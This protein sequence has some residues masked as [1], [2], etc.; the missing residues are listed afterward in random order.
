MQYLSKFSL[1]IFVLAATIF[2]GCKKSPVDPEVVAKPYIPPVASGPRII[3]VSGDSGSDASL[4][5]FNVATPY[6]TLQKA[7]DITVPGDEVQIMNGTYTVLQNGDPNTYILNITRSGSPGK[8][9]TYKKYPGAS[10]V[11]HSFGN[12]WIAVSIDAS[13]II[14]DGL[15]VKGANDNT[16]GGGFLAAAKDAEKEFRAGGRDYYKLSQYNT[17]GVVV[18][19][20]NGTVHVVLRNCIIHD[21]PGGGIGAFKADYLTIE[22]NRSYNNNWF[23]MYGGSGISVIFNRNSDNNTSIYKTI[24]SGNTSYNNYS[25]VPYAY[26]SSGKL[27]DGNGIII[28]IN[29]KTT[30]TPDYNGR[31][32]V[33]NNIVYGNGGSGIH[34]FYAQHVDLI[35]NTAYSNEKVL[36]YGN[37]GAYFSADV[38]FRNNIAYSK[39]GGIAFIIAR[40]AGTGTSDN[41]T[42]DYNLNFNGTVSNDGTTTSTH[43]T[44]ADPKFMNI[45]TAD[46]NL[47]T[48]SPAINAGMPTSLSGTLKDILSNQRLQGTNI[49]CGAY[50]VR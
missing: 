1:I 10:P 31:T 9:I 11:I 25:Q 17:N 37:L 2:S 5:P 26:S 38:K 39:N 50:E 19:N 20:K 3:Y 43:N 48:T 47:Q 24:V 40:A 33:E 41:I 32:L 27:S 22:N 6:K 49:D 15:E 46:F 18:G 21:F 7:S 12:N 8:Y 14:F 16:P 13:Y 42:A 4:N 30:E 23:G 28:D 35:N 44:V 29:Y 45:A 36:E 34:V